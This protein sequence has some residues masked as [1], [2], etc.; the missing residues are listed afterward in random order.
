MPDHLVSHRLCREILISSPQG[1]K[2]ILDNSFTSEENMV[3]AISTERL[4]RVHAVTCGQVMQRN[5]MQAYHDFATTSKID[6][7]LQRAAKSIDAN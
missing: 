5:E 3:G 6:F 7:Y 1:A 4:D 2:R